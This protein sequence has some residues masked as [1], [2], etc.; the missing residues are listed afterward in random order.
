MVGGLH[1]LISVDDYRRLARRR[2]P[3]SVFEFVDGGALDEL[4]LAD[5]RAG[6]DRLRLLG[7]V[8]RDVSAPDLS[9]G[10][11]DKT[12][13]TPL[14]VSPMGS[15]TLIWPRAEVA[16]ARAAAARG[17]PYTL[18][19]M[20]TI[21]LD[22]LARQVDGDLWFQL[23]VLKDYDFNRKLVQRAAEFGYSTLVVTVDLQTGGKRERDLRNGISIPL[24][25]SLRHVLEGLTHPGWA[26]RLVR[27]G[28]PQFE[29]VRDYIGSTNAGLT[30]AA[31]VAASLDDA[32]AM[33]DFARI[34]D[35]WKGRLVVKGVMH[36]SDAADLVA[37]GADGIWVSNHGGRQLDSAL[38][39]IDALPAIRD[40]IA[41]RVPL[42]LDSG[43]RRGMDVI[44]ARALGASVVGLG[45]AI[46]YGAAA[47]EAGVAGVLD[48]VLDEIANGLKLAGIP[49]Y[50]DIDAGLL[51]GHGGVSQ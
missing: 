33:E 39:S 49:R 41:G 46:A 34:R 29:N 47:G 3:K 35:W 7:R 25:L 32:M 38:S 51:A 1:R 2:L 19:T 15:N 9:V 44:K 48:I 21:G 37:A 42:L 10:L 11:W 6:F 22:R 5:N 50:R 45:R 16:I 20:S 31:R 13:P 8:L 24:R 36:A 27:G 14:V 28:A 12:Q 26:L 17:I 43:V 30:I 18:S 23:Y 40:A 4:T